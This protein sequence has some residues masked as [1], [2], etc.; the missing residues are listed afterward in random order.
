MKPQGHANLFNADCNAFFYQYPARSHWYLPNAKRVSVGHIEKCIGVLADNGVDTL[1]VN[2]NAQLAWYPSK[3]VQ[4]N[5]DGYKR[6]DRSHFFGHLLGQVMTREQLERYFTSMTVLMDRYLDLAEDGVNWVA[7]AATICRRKKVSPWLS[8]RMNDMHGA[9]VMPEF[10][11][12]NCDLYTDPKMRLRGTT[13]NPT[14]APSVG[15]QGFNYAK[16]PVRDFMLALIREC[17][18]EFEYEGIELDWTRAPLCCEPGASRKTR[19]I[20]T[21]WHAEI[22]A[23]TRRAAKKTGRPFPMGI[24]YSGT[25]DQLATIGL[26]VPAMAQQDLIDFVC[27]TNTWQT[28][29]DIP[30]DTL[31]EQL[32]DAVAVYGVVEAAPNWMMACRKTGQPHPWFPGSSA[33]HYRLTPSAAPYLRGNAAAKLALG[34]DGIETFNFF[35]TDDP[36][37]WWAD[38]DCHADYPAL[39]GLADPAFLRGKPKLYTFSSKSGVYCHPH[40]ETVG[41]FPVVLGPGCRHVTRLPMAAEPANRTLTLTMQAVIEKQEA[42]PVLGLSFNGAWPN[43]EATPTQEL[44]FPAGGLTRHIPEHQALNYRFRVPDIRAGWNEI[45]LIN[46]ASAATSGQDRTANA[47]RVVGLELAVNRRSPNNAPEGA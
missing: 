14:D 6:G 26:D 20:V 9:T 28:S 43:F 21:A 8:I 35:C 27:P 40:F 5:L 32:G 30:L 1:L 10:S 22:R 41:E 46:G 39:R 24:R 16:R 36:N 25:L 42:P 33:Q 18:E 12:M 7:E 4:T 11:M 47:V 38:V 45:V 15:W 37:P 29:W 19:D 17:V 2:T 44:L 13:H 31:K 3:A 34:A 23:L